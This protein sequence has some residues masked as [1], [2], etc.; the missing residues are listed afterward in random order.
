MKKVVFDMFN[1]EAPV[2]KKTHFDNVADA[3]AIAVCHSKLAREVK[4]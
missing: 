2:G 4:K 3:I 1:I